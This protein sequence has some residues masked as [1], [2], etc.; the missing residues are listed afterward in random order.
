[1]LG[2]TGITQG[3][4]DKQDVGT[5]DVFLL[6]GL[7]RRVEETAH[8][9]R[10]V[11][12]APELHVLWGWLQVAQKRRVTDIGPNDPFPGRGTI[13]TSLEATTATRTPY[14]TLQ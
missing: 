2:Q 6:F 5:G 10:F 13:L 4:L 7:Y 14:M 3:H 8:G 1:M 9:W 12:N 11:R